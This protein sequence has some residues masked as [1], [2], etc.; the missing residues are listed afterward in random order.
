MWP[1]PLLTGIAVGVGPAL[2]REQ[3][4]CKGGTDVTE[5]ER[6][7]DS[8]LHWGLTQLTDRGRT[9]VFSMGV[10]PLCGP[11]SSGGSRVWAA[12]SPAG[13]PLVLSAGTLTACSHGCALLALRA[14]GQRTAWAMHGFYHQEA[15]CWL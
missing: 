12:A 11:T 13:K 2:G 7:P 9:F 5:A 15:L 6:I 3:D 8:G 14:A 10:R 1:P 4:C